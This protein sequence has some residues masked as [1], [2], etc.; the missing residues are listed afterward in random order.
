LT[1]RELKEL[2]FN[3]YFYPLLDYTDKEGAKGAEEVRFQ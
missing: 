3:F 1:R 2:F